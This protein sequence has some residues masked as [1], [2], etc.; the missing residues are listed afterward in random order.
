MI[1]CFA[2][3]IIA[4]WH[5][6]HKPIGRR[7]YLARSFSVLCTPFLSGG[8]E[9][10][11]Q[12]W[13]LQ[14]TD[15]FP[16]T[17]QIQVSIEFVDSGPLELKLI[18]RMDS[19]SRPMRVPRQFGHVLWLTKCTLKFKILTWKIVW[20]HKYS[21]RWKLKILRVL[22]LLRPLAEMDQALLVFAVHQ[23]IAYP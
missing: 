6:R 17:K 20:H 15:E 18:A 10:R 21:N 22:Y 23:T 16:R 12:K 19:L 4:S 7:G 13:V 8:Q 11:S 5:C 3:A 2:Q 1:I 14:S 9:N